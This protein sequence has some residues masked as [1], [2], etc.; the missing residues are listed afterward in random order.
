MNRNVEPGNRQHR[1]IDPV[2]VSKEHEV[3]ALK[4]EISGLEEDATA[5]SDQER[6]KEKLAKDL[7]DLH[8]EEQTA[9]QELNQARP[10]ST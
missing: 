7:S 10:V 1:V 9:Q 4:S 5:A 3:T 8:T 6:R 2:R